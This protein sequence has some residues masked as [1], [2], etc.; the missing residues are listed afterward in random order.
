M[1]INMNIEGCQAF[2]QKIGRFLRACLVN[3]RVTRFAGSGVG[4]LKTLADLEVDAIELGHE[5]YELA[6]ATRNQAK[7]TILAKDW[8]NL[9]GQLVN[10]YATLSKVKGETDGPRPG[11]IQELTDE[12]LNRMLSTPEEQGE[13]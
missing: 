1:H 10:L 8:N 9:V 7:E 2:L 5:A 3:V 6:M 4:L 11:D 13:Y 12:E